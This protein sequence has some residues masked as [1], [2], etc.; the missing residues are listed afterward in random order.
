L[1]QKQDQSRGI[2]PEATGAENH[3]TIIT[4]APSTLR[5]DLIWAGTDDGMIQLT[6]D[7]G[8]TWKNTAQ[9]IKGMPRNSWV[10]QITASSYNPE[11]AFAVVND[12][13]Q[14]D[15]AAYLYH[16]KDQGRSWKRI[17]D[18]TDV[19]GYVLCFVQDPVEPRL[20][21]AGT[22]YGLYVSF[23][24]GE[25]WNEWTSGYP[26]VS[27]YDMVIHP[28]ENDLVI[29]TFG[30]AL[31]VLDDISPLRALADE[32]GRLLDS[33][34]TAFK[35]P[36]AYL[37]STKNLPGYYYSGDAMFRGENRPQ[38]AMISFYT[39]MDSGKVTLEI[40]ETEG[41]IIRSQEIDAVKGFNR[42]TW[43][44]DLNPL[45]QATQITE[46]PRDTRGRYFRTIRG[47]ALPGIYTVILKR[48]DSTAE[49]AVTVRPD[50]RIT[51][52]DFEAMR[53][54]I[55]QAEA[56]GELVNTLNA[57]LKNIKEIKDRFT[58][59]DE[60]IIKSSSFAEAASATYNTVKEQFTKLEEAL[61]RRPDGLIAQINGYRVLITASGQL[62]Q[63]EKKSMAEAEAALTEANLRID[64]FISGPWAA[65]KEALK[66]VTLT[67]DE[68]IK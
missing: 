67:G 65:Y 55:T 23:N 54:N 29:G 5:R 46:P 49:T 33:K 19:W 4:I 24:A 61:D 11:E 27:T 58:K 14:G 52:Q 51:G 38:G 50:P 12:Y 3:C 15:N 68:V 21:F 30:R 42:F 60:M 25:T 17:I 45:P 40:K 37:A 62:S 66:K 36:D 47:V 39:F 9:N 59:S 63:Q 18:D 6:V 20:M 41:K 1:K 43:G 35:V 2:T 13:R 44:L 26:T 48:G 34:M 8:K 56:F 53:K 28:R 64:D 16:T 7:G 32:G 57:K 22:E 31:W 10:P